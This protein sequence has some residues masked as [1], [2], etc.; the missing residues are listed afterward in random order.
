[1]V[2]AVLC[3]GRH[4]SYTTP[5]IVG[6]KAVSGDNMPDSEKSFNT[7]IVRFKEFLT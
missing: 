3:S 2:F 6:F 1:M 7:N 5:K 4:C